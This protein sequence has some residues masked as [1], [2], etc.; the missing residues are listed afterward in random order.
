MQF[1]GGVTA[2]QLKPIALEEDAVAVNPVGAEG[3]AEQDVLASVVACASMRR[4]MSVGVV[5]FDDVVIESS[6]PPGRCW[7]RSCPRSR[8]QFTVVGLNRGPAAIHVV[9]ADGAVGR[10]SDC[11]PTQADRA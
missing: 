2:V 3:T 8:S 5:G 4:S 7:S 1:A 6:K 9:G 10:R 11:R